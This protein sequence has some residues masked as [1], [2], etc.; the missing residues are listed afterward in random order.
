MKMKSVVAM[1]RA[2]WMV[3]MPV[4]AG[5]AVS[6]SQSESDGT[7]GNDISSSSNNTVANRGNTENQNTPGVASGATK[8]AEK[9]VV[10][11]ANNERVE[12][13]GT[14]KDS[15]GTTVGLVGNDAGKGS[16]SS[17]NGASVSI[18]TGDAEVAGL[19]DSAKSDINDLNSGKE[20]GEVI[21]NSGLEAYASVGG[22]RAI[23]S[24]NAAG[25]DVPTNVTLYVDDLTA[26]KEVAVA[27]YDN[28]PGLWVV[29]KNVPFN[30]SAK[31]V[32][33]AV[34]GSC[35]VQFGAK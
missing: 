17:D 12:V 22:T 34:P 33:F 10:Q 18:A 26:G 31:T 27:Y 14:T 20:P 25:Q 21:P 19:S 23:V 8:E 9:T 1:A 4:V 32:S 15:K 6:P 28:K 2:A 24:K 11:G 13:V 16:V 5:A 3:A 30:A 35:T 29:V 7:I